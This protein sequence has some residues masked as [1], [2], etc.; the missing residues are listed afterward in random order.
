MAHAE[1]STEQLKRKVSIP[2]PTSEPGTDAAEANDLTQP[3]ALEAIEFAMSMKGGGYNVYALGDAQTGMHERL[4]A[5]LQE[6]ASDEPAGS[7]L[8]YVANFGKPGEPVAMVLPRGVG[9]NVRDDVNH[10]LVSLTTLIPAAFSSDEFRQQ[11][12]ELN[13]ELQ[14]R[15]MRDTAELNEEAKREGLAML[16]T[17]GGFI[18]APS[19]DDKVLD[20]EEF[21]KLDE[22]QKR[23]IASAIEMMNEKLR[24]RLQA[25]PSFQE[26]LAR[27]QRTLAETTAR[28]VLTSLTSKLRARYNSHDEVISHLNAIGENLLD[29][30]DKLLVLSAPA[31][32]GQPQVPTED[33]FREYQMNLIVDRS[34]EVRAPVVYESNPSLENLIG[35]LDHRLEYGV[36]VSDFTMIRAGALHR[37][38]GGYLVLDAERLLTKPFAWEALKRALLDGCIRIESVSQLL[39]MAYSVSLDPEPVPLQIK[40]VLLGPRRLHHLLRQYDSDYDS[41]FKVPADFWDKVL[42]DDRNEKAYCDLLLGFVAENELLPLSDGALAELIEYGGRLVQDRRHLSAYTEELCDMVREADHYARSAKSEDI[43][44]DHVMV[45]ASQRD[46]RVGRIKELVL[47][48]I[49]RGVTVIKTEHAAVGQVNGLS[50]VQLGRLVFGQPS[51]ITATARMGR[52]DFIDIER[53]SKLGGNIHSKAVLIVSNFIGYRYAKEQPLSLHASLVFEQSYGGIEGDSASIAEVCALLSAIIDTPVRQDLA[54][55][56]SMDQHGFVQAI[57]GVNEKIEGFFEV[58]KSQK[59]TGTQGVIIPQSNQ[60]NL[61]LSDEVIETVEKGQF[62]IYTMTEVDDAIELMFGSTSEIAS[63]ER[64]EAQIRERL[65]RFHELW[66]SAQGDDRE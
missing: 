61:M 24:E 43:G 53:E 39:S 18:F 55:T 37:A 44:R 41:L 46:S 36:P 65:A 6:I 47:H 42:W 22:S 66:K 1:L 2:L 60:E 4:M 14:Q 28:H 64:I 9:R 15:Q 11:I 21:A 38:N 52:G 56:G 17:P 7:D 40:V 30:V 25:Y 12:D 31:V 48:N 26:E 49:E 54:I 62:H 33:L 20:A 19:D 51:R 27:Q 58:C 57:G 3:R 29:N 34:D 23:G 59:L 16:P 45:A 8:C 50:V 35:K 10:L 63:V 5:R 13:S 32:P